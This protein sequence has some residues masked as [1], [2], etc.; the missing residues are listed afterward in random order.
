MKYSKKFEDKKQCLNEMIKQLNGKEEESML[1]CLY[2]LA[3]NKDHFEGKN[4]QDRLKKTP[5][6]DMPSSQFLKLFSGKNIKKLNVENATLILQELHNRECQ[7]SQIEPRYLV[8]LRDT[9]MSGCMGF[10]VPTSNE[11]NINLGEINKALET[12]LDKKNLYARNKNTIGYHT[13]LTLIHETQHTA[14]ME[15]ALNFALN[16]DKKEDRPRDAIFLMLTALNEYGSHVDK[17]FG[18][19][20]F[21]TYPV[22]YTE[23]CSNMAIVKFMQNVIK[24]NEVVDN[25]MLGCLA[26]R[27]TQDIHLKE[28]P[29]EERTKEIDETVCQLFEYFKENFQDGKIKQMTVDTLE[30]YL[31]HDEKGN[32][33]FKQSLTND[34]DNALKVLNYCKQQN[35]TSNEFN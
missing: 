1:K 35:T 26:E 14:Q 21:Y 17:K 11:L 7:K 32:S 34:F 9:K 29:V 8:E 27:I 13:A 31:K 3:F 22:D 19:K 20:L 2:S 10:M 6:S 16:Y 18:E 30:S 28:K 25:D 24:D 23:H 15:N 5:Y 4:I 33:K 12:P